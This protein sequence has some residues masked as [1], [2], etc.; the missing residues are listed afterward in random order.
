MPQPAAAS[1]RLRVAGLGPLQQVA[2]VLAEGFDAF[3]A[4]DP[5][6]NDIPDLGVVAG[7]L[8]ITL[9][10]PIVGAD[11]AN[12]DNTGTQIAAIN[13]ILSLDSDPSGDD[14]REPEDEGAEEAQG[15]NGEG[16][17]LECPA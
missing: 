15:E 2:Q 3:D 13:A 6:N 5:L 16:E 11:A 10:P 12:G 1:G 9:I 8:N 14:D 4:L 17:P 7:T